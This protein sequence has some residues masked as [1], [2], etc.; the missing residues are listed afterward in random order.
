MADTVIDCPVPPV[1]EFAEFLSTESQWYTLG[2]FLNAPTHELDIIDSNY[3]KAGILRCYIEVYKCLQKRGEPLTW[4]H[5]ATSLRRMGN[6]TLAEKIH[7]DNIRPTQRSMLPSI[8]TQ[9]HSEGSSLR[10]IDQPVA[11]K[12]NESESVTVKYI[13]MEVLFLLLYFSY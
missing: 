11:S 4:D 7:A 9:P 3:S 13:K 10:V 2:T 8:S 6:H 1:D 12:L 5:I